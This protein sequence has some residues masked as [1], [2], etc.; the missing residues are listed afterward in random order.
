MGSSRPDKDTG[1][2]VDD[3]IVVEQGDGTEIS[4]AQFR[5]AV[6]VVVWDLASA[7]L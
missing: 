4:L 6:V 2:E 7:G 1:F 5:K 3:K